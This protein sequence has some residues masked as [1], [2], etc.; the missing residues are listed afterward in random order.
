VLLRGTGPDRQSGYEEA[1][2]TSKARKRRTKKPAD[3]P[4]TFEEVRAANLADPYRAARIA[5]VW[6]MGERFDDPSG[7]SDDRRAREVIVHPDCGGGDF[8]QVDWGD[9]DGGCYTA[10]FDGPI[11]EQRTRAYF[12]ALKSGRLKVLREIEEP[13]RAGVEARE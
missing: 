12:D 11:V 10:N 3:R 5:C 4:R 9:R 2:E 8:W 1:S 13:S 7:A 6:T